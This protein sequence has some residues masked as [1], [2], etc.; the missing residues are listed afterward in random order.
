[1]AGL[2]A[3]QATRIVDPVQNPE[4]IA[5][6]LDILE[7][8]SATNGNAVGVASGFPVTVDALTQWAARLKDEGYVLVPVTAIAAE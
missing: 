4:V 6:A 7:E 3:V 5:T 1:E 2:P 8:V